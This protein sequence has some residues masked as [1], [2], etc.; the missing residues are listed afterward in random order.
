MNESASPA[1]VPLRQSWP[2]AL[3]ARYRAAGYWRGE[4]LPGVLRERATRFAD[5]IAVV[6]GE[7]RLSYAALW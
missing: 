5:D 7:V 4:T 3:V 2:P 1:L 6:G